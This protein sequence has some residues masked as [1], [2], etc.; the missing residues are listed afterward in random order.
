MGKKVKRNSGEHDFRVHWKVSSVQGR[1]QGQV[2]EGP[3]LQGIRPLRAHWCV[4]SQPLAVSSPCPPALPW[5]R[6]ILPREQSPAVWGFLLL[7][8]ERIRSS[9]GLQL[10]PGDHWGSCAPVLPL[11][12]V[13]WDRKPAPKPRPSEVDK[14]TANKEGRGINYITL[15]T[16]WLSV[17]FNSFYKLKPGV[18][19][20]NNTL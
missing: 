13:V 1:G 3:K 18:M 17:S 6:R 14:W 16:L 5:W 2:G 12:A 8:L 19:F 4:H 9:P 15:C 20:Y 11:R 10:Q 7:W